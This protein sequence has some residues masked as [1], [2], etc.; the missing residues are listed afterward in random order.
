MRKF[1]VR[2]DENREAKAEFSNL[3]TDFDFVEFQL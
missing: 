3:K 2:I 1:Q